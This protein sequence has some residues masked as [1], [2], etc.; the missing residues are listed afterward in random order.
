MSEAISGIT[1]SPQKKQR[2]HL[3]C[4][5][6]PKR[7][8]FD[9]D[10]LE[11]PSAA[12]DASNKVLADVST[13]RYKQ[14]QFD[15]GSA[16]TLDDA[17]SIAEQGSCVSTASKVDYSSPSNHVKTSIPCS[18]ADL[19]TACSTDGS[20]SKALA[21]LTITNRES[22]YVRTLFRYNPAHDRGL[23]ARGLAFEHGDIIFVVNASD[24]EWW[25]ARYAFPINPPAWATPKPVNHEAGDLQGIGGSPKPLDPNNSHLRHAYRRQLG[26]IPSQ[27]RMERRQRLQAKRVQFIDR[28]IVINSPWSSFLSANPTVS[29]SEQ[30]SAGSPPQRFF[31]NGGSREDLSAKKGSS[32]SLSTTGYP[33]TPGAYPYSNGDS[34]SMAAVEEPTAND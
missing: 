19:T 8:I 2:P 31:G 25:Q 30:H 7:P 11:R 13:N 14:T 27:R 33:T 16:T 24:P 17:S 23:S 3:S 12:N 10:Q 9:L 4:L 18:E 22:I 20:T 15:S 6:S 28:D 32:S 1:K 34:V 21:T 5:H 26:I 29:G